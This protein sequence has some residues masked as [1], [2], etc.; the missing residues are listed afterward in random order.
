MKISVLVDDITLDPEIKPMHGLSI[1]I[2]TGGRKILFNTGP[3][4]EAL[5]RNCKSLDVSLEGVTVFIT[6]W[7]KQ[8]CGALNEL[9]EKY[10]IVAVYGPPYTNS[11]TLVKPPPIVKDASKVYEDAWFLRSI[12]PYGMKW[13]KEVA[14]AV[15]EEGNVD[16]FLGCSAYGFEKFIIEAASLGKLRYVIGG[17][18]LSSR[19]VIGFRVLGKLVEKYDIEGIVP[20]HCTSL[21]ARREINKRWG[22]FEESGAG[23]VFDV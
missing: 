20:L 12:G 14:L 4:L 11:V 3:S 9:L 23:L 10:G 1:L 16:L 13:Y 6:D 15:V 18:H 17:L 5:V 22:I 8:H 2:E 21:E 19:D 7:K